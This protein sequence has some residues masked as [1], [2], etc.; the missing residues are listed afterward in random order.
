MDEEETRGQ[1][2]RSE[3]VE[4]TVTVTKKAKDVKD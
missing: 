2:R 3:K 1:R 4:K